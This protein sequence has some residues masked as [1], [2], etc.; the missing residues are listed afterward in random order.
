MAEF[1]QPKRP[2]FV[3]LL[4]LGVLTIALAGL[5]RFGQAMALWEFVMELA[6]GVLPLYLA[7]TGLLIGIVGVAVGWGLW[8]GLPAS[9]RLASFYLLGLFAIYWIERIFLFRFEAVRVNTHFAL[10]VSVLMLV[11]VWVGLCSR[12]ATSFFRAGVRDGDSKTSQL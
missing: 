4:A 5:S 3:T 7:I 8:K 9:R 2:W 1:H 6:P 10:S 12:S 11:S